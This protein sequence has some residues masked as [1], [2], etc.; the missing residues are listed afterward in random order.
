MS[1]FGLEHLT[2]SSSSNPPPTTM[3]VL[4]GAP[5]GSFSE[6]KRARSALFS[7]KAKNLDQDFGIGT[8]PSSIILRMGA[9]PL[10]ASF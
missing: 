1:T 9:W 2:V 7:S 10:N 5:K 4:A 3:I 6:K 8:D